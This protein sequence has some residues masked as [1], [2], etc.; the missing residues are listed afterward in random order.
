MLDIVEDG[1]AQEDESKHSNEQEQDEGDEKSGIT[2]LV[3]R[4]G[5]DGV[6]TELALVVGDRTL[7]P[8][9]SWLYRLYYCEL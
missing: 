1:N 6:A 2:H 8:G 3:P 9:H 7:G 4:N 5:G